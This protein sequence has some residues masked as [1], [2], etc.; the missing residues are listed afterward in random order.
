MWFSEDWAWATIT[1]LFLLHNNWSSQI[2][3]LRMTEVAFLLFTLVLNFGQATTCEADT[4]Q[5][6]CY[7]ENHGLFLKPGTKISVSRTVFKTGLTISGGF[8]TETNIET[9]PVEVNCAIPPFPAPGNRT[10]FSCHL[11]NV[12]NL[13]ISKGDVTTPCPS[14]RA[15]TLWHAV[16]SSPGN[17]AYLGALARQDGLSLPTWGLYIL[18][19]HYCWPSLSAKRGR[20]MQQW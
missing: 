5:G 11:H 6:E 18:I 2:G 12:H 14:W 9:F 16:V 8:G 4:C 10:C 20:T 3:I 15:G 13:N 19:P 1:L 7:L 17:R